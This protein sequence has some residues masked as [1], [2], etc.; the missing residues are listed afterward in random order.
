M[1]TR[2]WHDSRLIS[3]NFM[4]SCEV[5]V[6]NWSHQS[7]R[8]CIRWV[9]S[10]LPTQSDSIGSKQQ[11]IQQFYTHWKS[12]LYSVIDYFV[13]VALSA[14]SNISGI[15]SLSLS[16]SVRRIAAIMGRRE[17]FTN[18]PTPVSCAPLFVTPGCPILVALN[19]LIFKFQNPKL[20]EPFFFQSFLSDV[21][22]SFLLRLISRPQLPFL[23]DVFSKS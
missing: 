16:R 13:V 1:T 23:I 17:S 11:R 18:Y 10:F 2:I 7:L 4:R 14:L 5:F 12:F 22:S 19:R 20:V 21:W 6:R 3:I 8:G 9:L 15:L